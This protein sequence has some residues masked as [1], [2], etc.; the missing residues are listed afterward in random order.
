MRRLPPLN[1][2]RSFEAAA[3]LGNMSAA[4]QELFVTHGAISKQIHLLESWLG[5]RLFERRPSGLLLT[6]AGR[7]Y[8]KAIAASLDAVASASSRIGAKT[9]GQTLRITAPPAFAARW[10]V[11]RLPA[12]K[13]WSKDIDISLDTSQESLPVCLRTSDVVIRRG[14]QRWPGVTSGLFLDESITPVCR[15]GLLKPAER[16]VSVLSRMTWL[17]TDARSEDWQTWLAAAGHEELRP[18]HSLHFDHSSLTIDAAVRGMGIAM[19]P[20]AMAQHEL[21]SGLLMA[22]FP[23]RVVQTPGYY[24]ICLPERVADR[25]VASFCNWLRHEAMTSCRDP[26]PLG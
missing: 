8:F 5:M 1:S 11:P 26:A 16:V 17:H 25:H 19:V 9:G 24:A 14:P 3:R 13:R 22:P 18:L 15:P 2:L 21:R 7:S 23:D 20:L 4:A 12:L 6:P 10:L